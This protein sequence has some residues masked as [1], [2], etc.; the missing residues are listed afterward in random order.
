MVV[1][2]LQKYV[3]QERDRLKDTLVA[4]EHQQASLQAR[5]EALI[6]ENA[7]TSAQI[8]KDLRNSQEETNKWRSL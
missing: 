7:R 2:C 1:L 3:E 6:E 4:M 5:S 8:S